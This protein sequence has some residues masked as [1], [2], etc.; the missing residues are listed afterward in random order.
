MAEENK[1]N[2]KTAE[3]KGGFDMKIIGVALAVVVIAIAAFVFFGQGKPVVAPPV[4]NITYGTNSTEAQL[5]LSSFDN[6]AA[7]GDYDVSFIQV[8]DRMPANISEIR[9]GDRLWI[10]LTDVFSTREGFLNAG[11]TTNTSTDIVCLS[12]LD[13]NRCAMAQNNGTMKIVG[14]LKAWQLGDNETNTVQKDGMM[15]LIGAGAVK[16]S[17][18]AVDEKV[19]GFDTRK[20]HYTFNLQHLTVK[21]L[22]A[23]GISPNDPTLLVTSNV[24]YWIDAATGLAVKSTAVRMQNGTVVGENSIE[25]SKL[26]LSAEKL[27]DAELKMEDAGSFVKF[28]SDSQD[29]FLS[30]ETCKAQPT[31]A[32]VDACYKSMS[33]G[34]NDAELCKRISNSTESEKCITIVAQNTKNSALCAGLELLPDDCYIAVAGENGNQTLCSLLKNTS[35][36]GDCQLAA[37]QGNGKMD[38]AAEAARRMNS[39]K[40]CAVDSDC[41]VFSGIACAPKNTTQKFNGADQF[42]SCYAGLACGCDSGFCAFAKNETYYQCV[43]SVEDN[44]LKDLINQKADEAN[45]TSSNLTIIKNNATA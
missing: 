17:G 44:L 10:R 34:K 7:I 19:G 33:V 18:P 16:I 28:Y 45:K 36:S 29:D 27:P 39:L 13:D 12:Y 8:Q 30:K 22:V 32:D 15:R 5:L 41:A 26:L 23:L 35:L 1:N 25:Y 21:E 31:M 24:T 20:I 6:A 4:Q 3:K 43:S 11:N 42:T 40:N 2:T 9:K 37:A 38:A 14:S